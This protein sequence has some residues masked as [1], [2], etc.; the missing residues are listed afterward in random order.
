MINDYYPTNT[1]YI[2]YANQQPHITTTP[3]VKSHNPS[4]VMYTPPYSQQTNFVPMLDTTTTNIMNNFNSMEIDD[5]FTPTMDSMFT[6][7]IYSPSTN[8]VNSSAMIMSP[9]SPTHM[10]SPS[11]HLMSPTQPMVKKN[12][13]KLYSSFIKKK[14]LV[15]FLLGY[16]CNTFF[17]YALSSLNDG[18][19]CL[20]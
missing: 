3:V 1:N 14:K 5:Y 4:S 9:T 19:P 20:F 13:K 11:N 16:V 12:L 8:S 17:D 18:K 10:M 15:F 6:S 2:H 7:T